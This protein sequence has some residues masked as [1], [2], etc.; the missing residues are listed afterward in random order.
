MTDGER[1]GRLSWPSLLFLMALAIYPYLFLLNLLVPSTLEFLG[2]NTYIAAETLLLAAVFVSVLTRVGSP[3]LLLLVPG[4]IALVIVALRAL[5]YDE[6]IMPLLISMRAPFTVLIYCGAAAGALTDQRT[7]RAARNIIVGNGVAQALVGIVHDTFF[8]HVVAGVFVS[9]LGIPDQLYYIGEPGKVRFREAG[10]LISPNVYANFIAVGMVVLASARRQGAAA[11][12]FRVS[13]ALMLLV[14]IWGVSLAGS[15]LP[16]AVGAA[17]LAYYILRHLSFRALLP[18]AATGAV[19]FV[20]MTPTFFSLL[21]RFDVE[22]SGGRGVKAKLAADLV[23]RDTSTLLL[24]A[25]LSA[26][27]QAS[28]QGLGISDNSLFAMTLAFGAPVVLLL[29]AGL[30]ATLG[31]TLPLS[32]SKLLFTYGVVTLALYNAIYWD[33]WLLYWFTGLY[34]M[35]AVPCPATIEPQFVS[36]VGSLEQ[37]HHSA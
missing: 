35:H 8:P 15:R 5:V 6:P 18:I 31:A 13:D 23:V 33:I 3:I 22:G 34:A 30:V 27:N 28:D 29:G 17:A 36:P 21:N 16:I 24:G 14:M 32:Q 19:A 11:K 37:A 25:P 1:P 2:K 20:M 9:M 7:R 10:I 4:M 26:Q 12:R